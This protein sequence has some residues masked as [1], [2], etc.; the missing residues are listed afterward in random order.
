MTSACTLLEMDLS[1]L[2][3]TPPSFLFLAVIIIIIII[4]IVIINL[5]VRD[6]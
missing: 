5:Q 2:Y 6:L 1:P 3:N 4:I